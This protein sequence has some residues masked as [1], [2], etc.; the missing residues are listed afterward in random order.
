M[1]GRI[2]PA[3]AEE[4]IAAVNEEEVLPKKK[5]EILESFMHRYVDGLARSGKKLIVEEIKRLSLL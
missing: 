1:T 5:M 4:L 2:S 3:E